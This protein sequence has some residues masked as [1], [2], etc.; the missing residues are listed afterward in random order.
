MAAPDDANGNPVVA[1][2]RYLVGGYARHVDTVNSVAQIVAQGFAARV[3]TGDA[4]KLS[5]IATTTYVASVLLAHTAASDPHPGYQLESE[6]GAANGYAALNASS[7]VTQDPANATATAT[8]SKIPIANGSGKLDSWVTQGAAAGT[9]SMRTLGTGAT[10]A[11]AGNDSRLSDSRA[12]TGSAGGDLTGT[13]PNPTIGSSK[14]TY[15]KMQNVSATDKLLGRQ[16]S[17]AGVV[18]EISCTSAGRSLISQASVPLQRTQLGLGSMA[19]LA[20]PSGTPVGTTDTQVLTNKNLASSTN[21]LGDTGACKGR[22]V[23][24]VCDAE[25]L[26]GSVTVVNLFHGGRYMAG[27]GFAEIYMP[28]AM[29]IV[30]L[31]VAARHNSGAGVANWTLYPIVNEGYTTN[32]SFSMAANGLVDNKTSSNMNIAVPSGQSLWFYADG[33][34]VNVIQLRVVV[35]LATA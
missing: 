14:V 19:L 10:D 28:E 35:V 6:K 32:L 17:G 13:Y 29:R 15:A 8:A 31:V 12:P 30:R 21:D 7:K 25:D 2:Q 34:A 22:L 27:G 1:G 9:Q 20:A 26:G 33:P 5:D 23:W 4:L 11:C 18:E 24:L 16:T 3:G